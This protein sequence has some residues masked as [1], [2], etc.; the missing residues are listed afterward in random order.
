MQK[1]CKNCG[2]NF[3]IFTKD[4]EFYKKFDVPPPTFC[5]ECRQQRRLTFR[6]ESN[7]HK[8]KCNLCN[9]AI[10]S[11][12]SPDK[13]FRK[14][15]TVLCQKCFFSDKWDAKKYGQELDPTKPFFEQFAKLLKRVPR[16]ALIN[17][18]SVNSEYTNI[19][20]HNK[21]SYLL[22]ESSDNE[23]CFYS[24]WIQKSENCADCSFCHE[25]TLCYE[26]DNCENCYNLNYSQNCKDCYDSSFLQ[27]CIGCKNCVGCT[28]LHRKEFHIFNKPVD[29]KTFANAAADATAK[30]IKKFD[31]TQPRKYAQ[32]EKSEDCTGDYIVNSRDC[33]N[34][35]HAQNA[36]H[37]RYAY[38]V[39]RNAKFVMDSDTV[40]MNSELAYECINTAINSYNNKFCNR[41]WTVS[42]CC[43]CNECDNSNNL[44]GCIGMNRHKY[45]ILNRRYERSEYERLRTQLIEHMTHTGEYGEFFP[46]ELSPFG[47]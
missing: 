32:I 34:C 26:C 25:C 46:V 35:F 22:V 6:N 21:N 23:D 47:D 44:F 24:Y 10:I 43:Y 20:E 17:R 28:N 13:P 41:C 39:W 33:F 31:A 5:P 12:Y 27:S 14:P 36:E 8:R 16:L 42:D 30:A 7:L 9:K 40:G 37:C 38:H 4:E 45:C 2:N 3:D 15:F 11:I 19:C 1:T 18:N 29:K